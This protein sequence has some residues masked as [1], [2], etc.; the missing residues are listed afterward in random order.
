MGRGQT[1]DT[2]VP[3]T[4]RHVSVSGRL[5]S[6]G[7]PPSPAKT[8]SSRRQLG[9]GFALLSTINWKSAKQGLQTESHKS[10]EGC[11][12]QTPNG[13]EKG[14]R[15]EAVPVFTPTDVLLF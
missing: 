12:W 14:G 8:P 13:T 6:T 3:S 9:G 7:V 10:S 2:A 5:G 15:E 11:R 4:S 1:K